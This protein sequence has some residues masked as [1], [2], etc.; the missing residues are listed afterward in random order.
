MLNTTKIMTYYFLIVT[1]EVCGFML[2]SNTKNFLQPSIFNIIMISYTIKWIISMD[3]SGNPF[4]SIYRKLAFD[5]FSSSFF[6]LLSIATF[7]KQCWFDEW[8]HCCFSVCEKC[9]I[10]IVCSCM[11]PGVCVVHKCFLIK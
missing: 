1:L 9:I 10:D 3:F 11:H 6:F 4:I 2:E 8:F 5:S 7:R